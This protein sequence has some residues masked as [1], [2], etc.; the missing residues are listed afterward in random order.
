MLFFYTSAGIICGLVTSCIHLHYKL[1]LLHDRFGLDACHASHMKVISI[2]SSILSSNHSLLQVLIIKIHLWK[3]SPGLTMLPYC[4]T[5]SS[6]FSYL[7]FVVI[8]ID[9]VIIVFVTIRIVCIHPA[10]C[11]VMFCI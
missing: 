10:L 4:N 6:I 5:D 2:L 7:S 1:I 8:F 9:S 11:C 3:A